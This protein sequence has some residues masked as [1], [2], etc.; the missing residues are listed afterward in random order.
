MMQQCTNSELPKK[1]VEQPKFIKSWDI[2]N[3]GEFRKSHVIWYAKP[4]PFDGKLRPYYAVRVRYGS[5]TGPLRT[6][7]VLNTYFPKP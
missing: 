6:K 3:Y 4:R 1:W 2:R 5:G 7:S